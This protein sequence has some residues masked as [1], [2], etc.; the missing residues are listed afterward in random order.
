MVV[1][2]PSQCSPP[3][4]QVCGVCSLGT[5]KVTVWPISGL[6][7]E[8]LKS[9]WAVPLPVWVTVW[10]RPSTRTVPVRVEPS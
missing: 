4:I 7:G 5:E 2:R 3:M 6:V 1:S 8:M 10:V 9:T